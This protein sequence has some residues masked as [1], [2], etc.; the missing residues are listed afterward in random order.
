MDEKQS[1]LK[2][3]AQLM[4]EHHDHSSD[5]FR[6]LQ[7]EFNTLRR[8][9]NMLRRV[10]AN[11]D[12]PYQFPWLRLPP[13]RGRMVEKVLDYLRKHRGVNLP[14]ACQATFESVPGG[15]PNIA[16]LRSY[17]YSI[18]LENFIVPLI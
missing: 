9:V 2:E 1:Q 11:G 5:E 16:S 12:D 17:C 6:H 7:R 14:R 8:E 3:L 4:R 13:A 18:K 15:Y 10:I